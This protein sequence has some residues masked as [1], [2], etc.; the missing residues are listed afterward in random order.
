[1]NDFKYIPCCTSALTSAPMER[2]GSGARAWEPEG[3]GKPL[4]DATGFTDTLL[5]AADD[6]DS[7][8]RVRRVIILHYSRTVTSRGC[9]PPFILQKR[10]KR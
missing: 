1:M 3:L 5:S 8:A 6:C 7:V 4:P 10:L 9:P 2:G